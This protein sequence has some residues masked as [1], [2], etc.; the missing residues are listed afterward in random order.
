ME[1]FQ[2]SVARLIMDLNNRFICFVSYE[3]AVLIATVT[4]GIINLG[5][6]AVFG[7]NHVSPPKKQQMYGILWSRVG[8]WKCHCKQ[9][10]FFRRERGFFVL[11]AL[12]RIA[13]E[14]EF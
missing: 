1:A 14:L 13:F 4:I 2:C 5:T 12:R 8:Y 9:N 6:R 7:I 11:Q 3:L 10:N